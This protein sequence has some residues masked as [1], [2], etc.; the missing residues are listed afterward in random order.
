MAESLGGLKCVR[1]SKITGRFDGWDPRTVYKLEDG[2]RWR[3]A[4]AIRRQARRMR[5]TARVWE[6]QYGLLFL[7]V[8][9]IHGVVHI[10][11][12]L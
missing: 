5:P 1:T 7:E 10:I 4:R 6:D 3:L 8:T 9:G 11:Q 12:V 2:S